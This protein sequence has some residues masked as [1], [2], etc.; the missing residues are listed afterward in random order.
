MTNALENFPI[1]CIGGSAGGL[2]A[3]IRLLQN[4]PA[5]IGRGYRQSH[6]NDADNAP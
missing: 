1:I 4:L 2:D 6:H 3:Y 5:D